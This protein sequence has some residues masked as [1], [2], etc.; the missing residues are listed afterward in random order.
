METENIN[1]QGEKKP[2]RPRIGAQPAAEASGRQA[3][4]DSYRP[5][6]DEDGANGMPHE[7]NTYPRRAPFQPREDGNNGGYQPRYNN[8]Y[9]N[10]DDRQNSYPRRSGSY[11]NQYPR[12]NY[13]YNRNAEG[14]PDNVMR[15][16]NS[17]GGEQG[18]YQGGYQQRRPNYQRRDNNGYQPRYNKKPKGT[19]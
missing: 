4:Y 19:R 5:S 17:E 15:S 13:D 18:G 16:D 11:Q 6:H 8:R 12:R 2:K 9:G 14:N 1:E 7:R 3:R 10:R